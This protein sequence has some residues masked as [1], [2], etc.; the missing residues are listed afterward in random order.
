VNE[1]LSQRLRHR[2]RDDILASE[3][4]DALD[5]AHARIKELETERRD[6]ANEL[7]DTLANQD[8]LTAQLALAREALT[9]IRSWTFDENAPYR[10]VAD[11][12]QFARDTLARLEDTP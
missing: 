3:V 8:S 2:Y 4:A 10:N 7:C 1:T 12:S 6:I 5:A 9:E 11:A